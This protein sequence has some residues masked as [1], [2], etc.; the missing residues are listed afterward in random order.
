MK[1]ARRVSLA[2][3]A[4][5]ML[6]LARQP[7]INQPGA[8]VARAAKVVDKVRANWKDTPGLGHR[9]T[10]RQGIRQAKRAHAKL[11]RRQE[12]AWA[13]L[14]PAQKRALAAKRKSEA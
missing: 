13:I 2:E 12:T 5:E 7:Y 4:R 6:G 8:G 10:T 9:I 1:T 3:A 14:S 11:R